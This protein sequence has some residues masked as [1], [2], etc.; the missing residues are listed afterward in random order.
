V[1][2]GNW[3]WGGIIGKSSHGGL[4]KSEKAQKRFQGVETSARQS[5]GGLEEGEEFTSLF[6]RAAVSK[7]GK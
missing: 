7:R 6:L 3:S 5:R 2:D 1:S 4:G